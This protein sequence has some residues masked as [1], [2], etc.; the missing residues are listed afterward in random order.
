MNNRQQ[1]II[2]MRSRSSMTAPAS[3]KISMTEQEFRQINII[4][5][6]FRRKIA[7]LEQEL[8]QER[9]AKL[10]YQQA[11][12]DLQDELKKLTKD[13]REKDRDNLESKDAIKMLK[14][15]NDELRSIR[16]RLEVQVDKYKDEIRG[17]RRDLLFQSYVSKQP[18]KSDSS[19]Q[20]SEMND[21]ET[22]DSSSGSGSTRE[23]PI[24]NKRSTDETVKANLKKR[25]HDSD[26]DHHDVRIKR[27]ALDQ[28]GASQLAVVPINTE[29]C[30]NETANEEDPFRC[31][32]CNE[33]F[34]SLFNLEVHHELE[35]AH[36]S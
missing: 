10:E 9:E 14:N 36:R 4:Q 16:S 12:Y 23:S 15:K 6:Q 27:Q 30:R 20:T 1:E 3:K 35:H 33:Q 21:N 2:N 17:L 13:L 34:L 31:P 24:C 8:A 7:S 11:T 19:T 25:L 26:V 28:F 29:V 18:T 5:Q 32:L 22:N